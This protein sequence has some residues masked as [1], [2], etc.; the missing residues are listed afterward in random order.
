[1]PYDCVV[2]FPMNKINKVVSLELRAGDEVSKRRRESI[3]EQTIK[4]MEID[5]A[6][7]TD[8]LACLIDDQ[9]YDRLRQRIGAA[10]RGLFSPLRVIGLHDLIP[11]YFCSSVL[12]NDYQS[13]Q[14]EK[15]FDCLIYVHGG[16]ASTDAG[17]SLTLAHELQHFIQYSTN[18]PIWAVHR[19][20]AELPEPYCEAFKSWVDFPIERE[21]RVV[22]KRVALALFD[23]KAVIDYMTQKRDERINDLDVIDWEFLLSKESDMLYDAVEHTKALVRQYRPQLLA[24]QTEDWSDCPDVLS[25]K[26]D[27]EEWH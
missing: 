7:I 8:T 23:R 6:Q 1:M 17:L 22:A 25:L 9:D 20:F 13:W 27:S 11:Q 15:L 3:C 26:L 16:T 19:L 2:K 24:V 21:A 14:V 12:R 18:R 10:N 5:F 4:H